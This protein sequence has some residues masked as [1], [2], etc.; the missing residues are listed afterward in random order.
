VDKII[1]TFDSHEAAE[2]A[3]RDDDAC[4]TTSQ[5]LANFLEMMAPVYGPTEGLQRIYRTRD[6]NEPEVR[7]RWWLGL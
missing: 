5:R 2:Q 4:L 1:R 3:S 6:F 7:D